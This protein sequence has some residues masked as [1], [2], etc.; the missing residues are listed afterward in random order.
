MK[1][2]INHIKQMINE[3][4]I[5]WN[6]QSVEYMK[7]LTLEDAIINKGYKPTVMTDINRYFV[8]LVT[9]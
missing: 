1:T 4:K 2:T 6:D 7:G 8:K 9:L 5:I 3:F